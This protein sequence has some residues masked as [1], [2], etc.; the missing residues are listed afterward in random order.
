M[1]KICRKKE[2]LYILGGLFMIVIAFWP[3]FQPGLYEG[4]DLSFHLNRIDSLAESLRS[5]VF[6]VKLHATRAFGY[7]YGV[8]FFYCNFFLYIPA[9]LM[10]FG[11]SLLTSYKVFLFLGYIAMFAAMG[12][13]LPMFEQM[14]AQ[15]LK[16][17][18]PWTASEENVESLINIVQ[19][20]RGL[21]EFVSLIYILS[22]VGVVVLLIKKRKSI[23][24]KILPVMLIATG[25]TFV[26]TWGWWWHFINSILGIQFLQFPFRLFSSAT[27]LILLVFA[28][29][30]VEFE[31]KM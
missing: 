18:H 30:Y 10:N 20:E 4:S 19:G 28:L 11:M 21:G 1:N 6:P 23:I 14:L 24:H 25:M 31:E 9:L 15:D 3:N 5:G 22:V 17:N 2:I 8:G 27:V 12:F 7:G 26:T 13:W 16:V 29:I